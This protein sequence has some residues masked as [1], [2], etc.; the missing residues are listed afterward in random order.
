[1]KLSVSYAQANALDDGNDPE[2]RDKS[3]QE[4]YKFYT[5]HADRTHAQCHNTK[6]W[7][8]SFSRPSR[9]N[10]MKLSVSCAKFNARSHWKHL[11]IPKH[12][13][14]WDVTTNPCTY[15][16]IA[17]S[18]KPCPQ[19]FA[20]KTISGTPRCYRRVPYQKSFKC[21]G[22]HQNPSVWSR[23]MF[24]FRV[25]KL[26]LC[27]THLWCKIATG[28]KRITLRGP[29]STSHFDFWAFLFA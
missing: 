17:L 19:K 24:D 4:K 13:A 12:C 25:S 8:R 1:M 2:P 20:S 21:M 26:D 15:L 7:N 27:S 18:W 3:L 22:V 28:A 6:S 9:R 5:R 29:F 16:K 14:T 11:R 23:A 10:F